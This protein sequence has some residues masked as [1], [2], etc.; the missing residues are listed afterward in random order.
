LIYR[1]KAFSVL[2]PVIAIIVRVGGHLAQVLQVII[3]LLIADRL[4]QLPPIFPHNPPVSKL[5]IAVCRYR[6][7]VQVLKECIYFNAMQ[8]PSDG[9]CSLPI[10]IPQIRVDPFIGGIF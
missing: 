3:H 8:I 9:L 1:K 2:W 4:R 7:I 5:I 6:H 10:G